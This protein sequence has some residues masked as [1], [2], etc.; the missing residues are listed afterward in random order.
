M[1][2]K[3]NA[4]N[5]YTEQEQFTIVNTIKA[6][7]RET[8]GEIKVHVEN[9]CKGNP[10][11]KAQIW[12]D[13]LKLNETRLKNGVLIYLAVKD[14]RFA[15]IGDSGIDDKVDKGFWNTV[16]FI[17]QEHF[18]DELY[19][20]GVKEA[21]KLVGQELKANFPEVENDKNEISDNISFGE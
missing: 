4:K 11:G 5:F 12:F 10:L 9:K 21:I 20:V 6:W 2:K 17:L 13:K 15:V 3:Q 16:A 1:S 19:V 18:K 7:E 14:Q 8:S